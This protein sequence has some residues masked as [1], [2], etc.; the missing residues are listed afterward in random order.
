MASYSST[1]VE[2]IE[3]D[4]AGNVITTYV[5]SGDNNRVDVIVSVSS[6]R[7]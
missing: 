1:K 4:D 3:Y 5:E 7:A 2:V 6:F